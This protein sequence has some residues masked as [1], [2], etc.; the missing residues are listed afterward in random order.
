MKKKRK[1]VR[2]RRRI[3]INIGVII[4]GVILVY[5]L[6]C[7]VSYLTKNNISVY[8]VQKGQIAKNTSY[9]GLILRSEEVCYS[10]E[11]GAVNYYKKEG[12]KAGY[13]DLICSIDKNGSIS[14]QISQAGLDGSVLSQDE[15]NEIQDQITEY[16]ESDSDM[17]FYNIYSFKDNIN[18]VV[19]E[20]LYLNAL[21]NLSDQTSSAVS[22]NT[23]SFVTSQ[24][25]GV[26]AFYTDG[27]ESI[28]PDN[29]DASKYTPS[30]YTKTNLKSI[31][32]VSSGQALYK[33]ITDEDWYIMVPITKEEK[34]D[35]QTY[36]EDGAE[37]FVI[38]VSFKKDDTQ[39]YATASIRD[40]GTQ[41]FL[42]LSFNSSMIRFLS[43]RYLEVELGSDNVTGLKIP[44]SAITEKEFLVIPKEYVGKGD[45]S[46]SDGVLKV[47][48][49]KKGKE[50]VEFVSTTLYYETDDA[51][52]VDEDALSFGDTI[53]MQDS[54]EQYMIKDTATLQGVYNMNKGYAV[55][56]QIDIQSQNEEY[57]I[58]K[59]G[60]SYGI[61]L[62]DHIALDG[63][64]IQEG[65]FAN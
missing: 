1:V 24:T 22:Q 60:T 56:K 63:S 36:M 17:Q 34:Q 39:T 42:Q 55:F 3:H 44:N 29:F 20:D 64:A 10:D 21:N 48:V 38:K 43:D 26:L 33:L 8:E 11:S 23:F 18:A 28:T 4:F 54:T 14:N 2:Y 47:T 41:S 9:T 35:Y 65:E 37:T 27:Y 30:T 59:T 6:I 61:A 7:L 13:Q 40:Y 12:D 31:T 57:S 25:D 46:S 32:S 58:I 51:Y 15:L 5:L 53:Q 50:S 49:D 62:Y 19:Q 16:I 45:D 52:Y